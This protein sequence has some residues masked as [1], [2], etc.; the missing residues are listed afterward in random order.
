M[1]QIFIFIFSLLV[2]DAYSQCTTCSFTY[3]GTGSTNFNLNGSQTLCITG[4]AGDLNI[5]F[6]G[7]GNTICIANGVTWNQTNSLNLA[8]GTTINVNNGTFTTSGANFNGPGSAI[9]IG[10][11]GT[12]NWSAGNSSGNGNI[13]ITNAG[14]LNFTAAG[15]QSFSGLI[16]NNSGT[17]TK[18][19]GLLKFGTASVITNSGEMNLASL[20]NEEAISFNNSGAINVTGHFFNHGAINN[21]ANGTIS[22]GSLRV[23]NKGPGKE[24]INNGTV[25]INGGDVLFEGPGINN[26]ALILTA[27]SNLT[28]EKE[29]SGTNGYVYL[30]DG[31]STITSGSFTGTQGFYDAN[32]APGTEEQFNTGDA[33]NSST[34]P[35]TTNALPV[36]LLYFKGQQI[37][38]KLVISWRV[39]DISNFD[40]FEIERSNDAVNF[41]KIGFQTLSNTDVYNYFDTD[42]YDGQNYYRLKLQD[43]DGSFDYSKIISVAFERNGEYMFFENPTEGQRVVVNTNIKNPQVRIFDLMGREVNFKMAKTSEGF[44][45]TPKKYV[46]DVLIINVNSENSNFTKRA[47]LR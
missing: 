42:P 35:A 34:N 28:L 40:R 10:S 6:N 1:K 18:T 24:F 23:G 47:I 29:L 17:L 43:L 38:N 7:T 36:R 4:N 3:N 20:E 37:S 39:T 5:N 8:A 16:L 19:S 13:T 9:N 30:E 45:I 27:G 32:N 12:L 15:D 21:E 44:E 26:G 22:A 33:S 14:A 41:E 2:I 46:Y 11:T 31:I 25:T